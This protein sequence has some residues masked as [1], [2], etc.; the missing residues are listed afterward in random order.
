MINLNTPNEQLLS[1]LKSDF[2]RASY[3]LTKT[4][5]GEKKQMQEEHRLVNECISGNK[6]FATGTPIEYM[7]PNGNRW[8]LYLRAERFSDTVV[9]PSVQA[10]CYYETLGSIGAFVPFF[11]GA[12]HEDVSGCAI[13]TSHFF[14]RMTERLGIGVKSREVVK[15]FVEYIRIFYGDIK[16]KGTHADEEIDVYLQGALGRGKCRSVDGSIYEVNTFLPENML[17]SSQRKIYNRLKAET[18]KYVNLPGV[19]FSRR[20][21]EEGRYKVLMD[22]ERNNTIRGEHPDY[23][24]KCLWIAGMILNLA[25]AM[26]VVVNDGGVGK[27]LIDNKKKF[28]F[29]KEFVKD[30][31]WNIDVDD[32]SKVAYS[33][34]SHF[35]NRKLDI[36]ELRE[37]ICIFI[38]QV[39]EQII[40]ER[41]KR[42]A[43]ATEEEK[44]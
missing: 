41:D 26:N 34:L 24:D 16:G 10:F 31:N 32:F 22:L 19:V 30:G 38:P 39:T 1:E 33:C 14:A 27:W 7:S 17:N 21:K 44:Q 12:D 13:F 28:R 5:G 25:K 37:T 9:H 15:L 18:S 6:R 8:Y 20:V 11:S 29:L 23:I 35:T 40:T 42:R 36:Q 3:W 2:A 43:L 4:L